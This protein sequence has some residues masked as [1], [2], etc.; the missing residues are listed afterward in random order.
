MADEWKA[1]GN[2]ALQQGDAKQAIEYFTKG[3]EVDSTNAILYS[4]R[5][6]AHAQLSNWNNALEDAEG[7]IQSKPDWPKGYSRKGLALLKLHRYESAISAY[8]KALELEPE[9]AVYK[10]NL[11][12]AQNGLKAS[13]QNVLGEEKVNRGKPGQAFQFFDEAIRL[14]PSC[15][16]YYANRSNAN[17]LC[18]RYEE[19]ISDADNVIRLRPTWLRGFQRRAEALCGKQMYEEAASVYAYCLQLEPDNEKI[20]KAFN[21]ARQEGYLHAKR[22]EQKKQAQE[23]AASEESKKKSK[24]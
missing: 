18:G 15:A 19:A 16:L 9:N 5:S 1:K 2:A 3:L 12:L 8:E 22:Q 13:E 21:N 17:T 24:K 11:E 10:E 14:D 6:A 7:A 20:T 4:N 23:S